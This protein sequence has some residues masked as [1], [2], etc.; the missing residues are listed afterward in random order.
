MEDTLVSSWSAVRNHSGRSLIIV[1]D[2][3]HILEESHPQLEGAVTSTIA[4][5]SHVM[6]RSQST[7]LMMMD[8]IRKCPKKGTQVLVVC[9]SRLN[10][11]AQLGRFDRTYYLQ[12]PN[13]M[14]RRLVVCSNLGL[15]DPFGPPVLEIVSGLV[16]STVGRSYSELTTYCRQAI[17]S[18]AASEEDD[19]FLDHQQ[20]SLRCLKKCL[21]SVTPDSLR[22]GLILDFVDMRVLT[23]RDL[24]TPSVKNVG[25]YRLPLYGSSILK[26]WEEIQS[27]IVVPLCRAR[28]LA[29]LVDPNAITSCRVVTGGI[30]LTGLPGTGKSAIAYHAARYSADL[31]QSVKLLDVSCTSLIHKEV[32]G[33]ERAI[34][35]LFDCARKAAPCILLMDGIE[36]IAA[37]RGNDVT[38]EGT[39]DRVLSTLLVELDGV[40]DH[41]S[42]AQ[43]GGIAVIGITYNANLIDPALMRPG[44]LEKV[45]QLGLPD[46]EARF[47][48]I[49]DHIGDGN[50]GSRIAV[51]AAKQ[52]AKDTRGMSASSIQAVCNDI[53]LTM[54]RREGI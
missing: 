36:N 8:S 16:E 6:T 54:A 37:V 27:S 13:A 28:E 7:M 39:M 23:A 33:S 3:E 51:D 9:S 12:P 41:H 40:D 2:L 14:E 45:V 18:L 35:H 11:D 17:E 43:H 47:R 42:L 10:V 31:V 24:G 4:P 44:R 52:L 48:I 29:T 32:G 50:D 19:D 49:C 38:T 25:A 21:Q 1:D 20:A 15:E 30:L 53:I 46:E 22:N 34:H 26:A 5:E